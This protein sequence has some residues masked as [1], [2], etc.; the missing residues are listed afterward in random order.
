M[1]WPLAANLSMLFT[2]EPLSRRV[3]AAT[4]AGFAGVEIQ[5]PY[6]CPASELEQALQR[7]QIPLVLINLPAADL[8]QGGPGLASVPSRR[9]D[10]ARALEQALAYA[11]RVR[12]QRVNV[13]PGRFEQ[14]LEPAVALDCLADNLMAAANAFA[15]LGMGVV[16]EAINRHDM[17][18]FVLATAD[19]LASMLSRV[20][21]P[22]LS[23][24][25]DFYHMQ[26]MGIALPDA[27]AALAGRIGHVQFADQPGRGA[28][29]SGQVDFAAGFGALEQAGYQGWLAAEYRPADGDFGW[30]ED[31]RLR[32]WV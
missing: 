25:L 26:R 20:A 28:P 23:A 16:C 19:E 6:D 15:Q 32:S 27:V 17:P 30:I 14:G 2:A 11:E 13:L 12:P 4:Q 7:S 29:G 3:V 8:L 1:V 10:F 22:N 24:Q 31:W 5:F 18:G 21:H 9:P